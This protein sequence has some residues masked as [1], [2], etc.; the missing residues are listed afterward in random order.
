MDNGRDELSTVVKRTADAPDA[1]AP[2]FA[3]MVVGGAEDGARVELDGSRAV[4][5]LVGSSPV[6]DLRLSDR[7]V[8]RRHAVLEATP[9][10]LRVVDLGSRNGVL[11]S[12]IAVGEAFL[13]GGETIVVGETALHVA[14][15]APV[16]TPPLPRAHRFGRMVGTSAA[17]RRLYPLCER[18]ASSSVPVLI[19]G[20][21]GTGK[22]V[23]AEALHESSAR[24]AGPFCVFD[25]ASVSPHL[26]E[27]ALFGHERGSFT[28]ASGERRGVFEEAHG[29]TLLID[30]IGELDLSLQP[31]LLRVLERG[32]V[33]RVGGNAWLKVDVRVLAA[34]R[35]DLDREVQA[36]RFR[37]DLFYRLAVGRIALPPLRDRHG[38]I[39]VLA[40]QFWRALGADDK[41]L[42]PEIL[43]RFDDYPWPGNVREL[44]NAVARFLAVGELVA[45]DL[46]ADEGPGG[47]SLPS[48]VPAPSGD[49]IEAVLDEALPFV[50]AR[51][52]V[53]ADFERRYVERI[54]AKH[55]GN[56]ARAA[57]ASGLAR[58]YFQLIRARRRDKT[59][60]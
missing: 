10:G 38:D 58:R 17:M 2:G 43:A 16:E 31:K 57:A 13:R 37:D 7:M 5:A 41:P 11:V 33:Q 14:R 46:K 26:L 12:G 15:L 3:V 25:C 29:G 4:P 27:S 23:L 24:A 36:G 9:R 56:V 34:T 1:P 20:E 18:L 32:E 60:G 42:S 39:P 22:E 8:S 53:V 28:G 55:G 48:T 47:G 19:E 30:E 44:R 54:L 6:C 21:T 45:A 50:R 49:V 59:N 52:R 40:A 51:D 35:R